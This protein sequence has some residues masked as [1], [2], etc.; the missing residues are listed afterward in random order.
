[1]AHPSQPLVERF[2]P[3]EKAVHF[4]IPGQRSGLVILIPPIGEASC[5]I[6]KI[7]HVRQDL[8]WRA[9]SRP[10]TEVFEPGGAPRRVLPAR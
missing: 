8:A 3:P 10:G 1:V 4:L 6:E 5:P 2:E 7:A 9:R